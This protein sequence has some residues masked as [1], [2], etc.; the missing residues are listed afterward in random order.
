MVAGLDAV[1]DD[2]I[3]QR[4]VVLIVLL[5]TVVLYGPLRQRLT[6]L[7]RRLVLGDRTNP[8]DVVAGLA[9]TLEQSDEGAQQLAAVADAVASAFGISY[10]SLEVDR[11][12]GERLVATH[13][14]AP[15]EVRT[16][17]ITYRGEEVGRVVLPGPRSAQ[18]AVPARRAAAR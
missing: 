2:D 3:G 12:R 7:V 5:L 10:V 17:P 1:L 4:Q 6:A 11:A 15:A 14:S 13:G 8:Y 16:L 9:S 18:P